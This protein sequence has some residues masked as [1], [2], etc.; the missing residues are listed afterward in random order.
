MQKYNFYKNQIQRSNTDVSH[1]YFD[2][3]YHI[4]PHFITLTTFGKACFTTLA[5]FIKKKVHV[6]RRMTQQFS[7]LYF[8]AAS[9]TDL[10][11]WKSNLDISI[12][13]ISRTW[14]F[15]SWNYMY[16]LYI[17]KL[18][19]ETSNLEVRCIFIG[20]RCPWG[21]IYG[22]GCLSQT[23]WVRNLVAD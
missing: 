13:F 20:P 8:M 16:F 4:L 7:V 1:W 15:K 22:S 6:G 11:I 23:E 3:L 19:H 9:A 10:I 14:N 17:N 5:L 21:P 12:F 18:E 2:H